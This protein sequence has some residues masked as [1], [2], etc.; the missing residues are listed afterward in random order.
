VAVATVVAAREA[1]VKAAARAVVVR[2]EAAQRRTRCIPSVV[3]PRCS[4][5]RAAAEAAAEAGVLPP[6]QLKRTVARGDGLFRGASPK[7]RRTSPP[8]SAPVATHARTCWR[9]R[10][11]LAQFTQAGYSMLRVCARVNH[12]RLGGSGSANVRLG[13]ARAFPCAGPPPRWSSS[14]N[15]VHGLTPARWEGAG[16]T[17]RGSGDGPTRDDGRTESPLSSRLWAA[18]LRTACAARAVEVAMHHVPAQSKAASQRRVCHLHL[19][20]IPSPPVRL[21]GSGGGSGGS[22]GGSGNCVSATPSTRSPSRKELGIETGM[23]GHRLQ[24]WFLLVTPTLGEIVPASVATKL[25]VKQ[26]ATILMFELQALG[27]QRPAQR[28]A[29]A[30]RSVTFA[31][32]QQQ[33]AQHLHKALLHVCRRSHQVLS[34][35]HIPG[36][37]EC[38]VALQWSK[39]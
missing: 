18:A 32:Q 19:P 35:Q 31:A 16:L 6:T 14:G 26:P 29:I 13:P 8:R 27:K 10:H 7:A 33:V 30:R 12:A 23:C 2:V 3:C 1:A 21:A 4:R 5:C 38:A 25:G 37:L 9:R 22:G 36:A 24:E 34:T 17:T 11:A 15:P 28:T 20:C 39:S